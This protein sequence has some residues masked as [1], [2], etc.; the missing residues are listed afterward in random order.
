MKN[1]RLHTEQLLPQEHLALG[2]ISVYNDIT[3]W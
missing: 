3:S 2:G 1:T